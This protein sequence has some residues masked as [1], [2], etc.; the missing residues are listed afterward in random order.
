MWQNLSKAHKQ[1]LSQAVSL[2]SVICSVFFLDSSIESY[3]PALNHPPCKVNH[4]A[5]LTKVDRSNIYSL[6]EGIQLV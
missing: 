6:V 2:R 5:Q 3:Q 1:V 4:L